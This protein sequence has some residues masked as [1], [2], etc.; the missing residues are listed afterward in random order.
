M[1]NM[2]ILD[3]RYVKIILLLI[4]AIMLNIVVFVG[5]NFNVKGA[6]TL[7]YTV[8][9]D[10]V[11]NYQ[12]FYS[13]G[14]EWS[15]ELSVRL[16]YTTPQTYQTLKYSLPKEI[17]KV[18]LDLGNKGGALL[19]SNI[20]INYLWEQVD[21]SN[22]ILM[23]EIECFDISKI[24]EVSNNISILTSGDDPYIVLDLTDIELI[25]LYRIDTYMNY[26]FKILIC[27]G[28]DILLLIFIKKRKTIKEL[29]QELYRNK[30]LIWSLSKN[31]FKTKYAGSYLGITWAFIQPVVTVLVYWFV[32]Q[33]GLRSSAMEDF[34]FILWLVSGLI[35]WF[36]FSE[37]LLNA[38]NSMTEYSYLVKKV[39]F[40][41]SILPIVK[42][43]SS[44]FVHIFF[45]FFMIALF[46]IYGYFP[47]LY[48]LQVFYYTFCMFVLVLGISYATC[49]TVIF[50]KDLGQIINIALQIGIWMTP[51]MWSHNMI[52]DKYKWVFKINPMYYIVEGYRDALINKIWFWERFNQT[53]Y[54]WIVAIG[55]FA[56][57]AIIFKRLKEHF[58]DV[59]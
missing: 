19:L 23:K 3:N 20:S 56:M 24:T 28:I 13:N 18:R 47:D 40:K 43:I 29:G 5:I 37:A 36:F 27:V 45:V 46:A 22:K 32:F 15:E 9:A 10:E 7:E 55:L 48:M 30:T 51:I 50:F 1:G 39:V 12:L 58:A 33:V 31:D 11:D 14:E 17:K 2:R 6:L 44:L 57:G 49:A 34:P 8:K 35:P 41:I 38:T 4:V 26:L 54:F 52:P 16:D 21:I 53:I 59:L 42:V 25:K